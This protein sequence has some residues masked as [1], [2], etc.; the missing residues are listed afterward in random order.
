MT[1][2]TTKI[3]TMPELANEA[4]KRL[5]Q[6]PNN[7]IAGDRFYLGPDTNVFINDTDRDSF[8]Y[9]M[10]LLPKGLPY[11]QQA[12]EPEKRNIEIWDSDYLTEKL[13]DTL[14]FGTEDLAWR[15]IVPMTGCGEVTARSL[16]RRLRD[17]YDINLEIISP[18]NRGN[19]PLLIVDDVLK[20]GG[21]IER[22]L[23]L[24]LLSRGNNIFAVWAMSALSQRDYLRGQ[25]YRPLKRITNEGQRIFAGVV[26]AGAGLSSPGLGLPVNSISTLIN[27]DDKAQEVLESLAEKYFGNG[28]KRAV[29]RQ[30]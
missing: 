20:T 11:I 1:N 12:G 9:L 4:Y 16:A 17:Y 27:G 30:S 21:T 25:R 13:A 6:L 18:E 3:Y 15:S 26:Y 24:E 7:V 29:G 14:V 28:I 22:E 2:E 19:D 10:S 23:P 5:G 8:N